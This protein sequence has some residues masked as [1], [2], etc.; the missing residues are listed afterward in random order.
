VGSVEIYNINGACRRRDVG[1][2]VP[3]DCAMPGGALRG[4]NIYKVESII[5]IKLRKNYTS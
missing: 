1:N 5:N 2:T 3:S 4:W